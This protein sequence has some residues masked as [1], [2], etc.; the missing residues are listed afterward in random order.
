M[1]IA[2]LDPPRNFYYLLLYNKFIT[3]STT[4]SHFLIIQS[5]CGIT[6][7][8]VLFITIKTVSVIITAEYRVANN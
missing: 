8:V 3:P 1:C 6:G 5:V 4:L 7:Q 2:F